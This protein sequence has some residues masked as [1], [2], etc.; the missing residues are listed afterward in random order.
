MKLEKRE[1]ARRETLK[2]MK[3]RESYDY[4]RTLNPTRMEDILESY[5]EYLRNASRFDY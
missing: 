4:Y 3:E 2:R 1:A 5:E